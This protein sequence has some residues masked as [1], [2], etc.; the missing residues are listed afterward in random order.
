MRL[1]SLL[2]RFIVNYIRILEE[3][4]T[5]MSNLRANTGNTVT[6]CFSVDVLGMTEKQAL[7]SATIFYVTMTQMHPAKGEAEN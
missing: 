1:M 5:Q 3:A 6:C 4:V 2:N 7:Q